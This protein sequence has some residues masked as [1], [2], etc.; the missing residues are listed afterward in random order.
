MNLRTYKQI[1]FFLNDLSS[2]I[3]TPGNAKLSKELIKHFT[4]S[5]LRKM[6]YWL[7]KDVWSENALG[8]MERDKLLELI[9]GDD[10]VLDWTIHKIEQ[11]M[12]TISNYSQ[13]E[14]ESFFIK[15][16]N[17]IHYLASKPV[18]NWDEYDLSNYRNLLLKTGKAKKVYA[19]F[20]ADV[21][22]E[23]VYAVTTK[24]SYFF[25]TKKEAE[26]EIKSIV[27]EGQF[28]KDELVV[29]KLWLLQ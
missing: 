23:D 6:I 19:V 25:D 5:E 22:A 11:Q 2:F 27:A 18:E 15:T 17:E 10:V 13:E 28:T 14:V 16:Q 24:P 12:T 8:F 3:E 9:N 21:L 4:D 7:Y 20:T 26:A 1:L 29:H